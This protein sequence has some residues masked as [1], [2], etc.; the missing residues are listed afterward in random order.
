MILAIASQQL[1]ALRRQ[2]MFVA[3]SVTLLAM[4]AIAGMLGWSSH[5]TIAG[6][7]EEA[8]K[9]LASTGQPAPADPLPLQPRLS[10]LSNMVIYIPLIGALL[11]LLLGHLIIADDKSSGVGRLVFSRPVPRS[12]YIMGKVTAASGVL[13]IVLLLSLVIAALSLLVVNRTPPTVSEFGRLVLF[14]MLSWL[15]LMV[16]A[17]IG[18][19]AVLTTPRRSLA[20]LS[21]M[22]AWLVITFV[23]P[24]FTS[25]LRPTASLNPILDPAGTSQTF[26][27]ITSRF[28]PLSVVEQY[29]AASGSILETSLGESAIHTIGRSVP[30]ALLLIALAVVA[31]LVVRHQDFSRGIAGE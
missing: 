27:K 28:R 13:A 7:Y 3:L 26:F 6:V 17:L 1:L 12:S 8:V 25:G 20:L 23:I 15:Y 4:T 9:L 2:G 30:I 19:I 14:Y 11:A 24:Q 29:K 21:A 22:G 10:L 31:T 5:R 16:F 18:M